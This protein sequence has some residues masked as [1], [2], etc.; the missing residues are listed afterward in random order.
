M[1]I[2]KTIA[3]SPTTQVYIWEVTESEGEL[4]KNV[5]LSQPC[6]V[7]MDGM[8]SEAHRRAFLSIRHL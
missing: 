4:W 2:Y 3:V 8:K 6:Q 7:R 5:E 1:P